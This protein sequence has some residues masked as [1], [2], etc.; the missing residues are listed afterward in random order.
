MVVTQKERSGMLW[1]SLGTPRRKSMGPG[2]QS[3]SSREHLPA[4]DPSSHSRSPAS[5]RWTGR[6]SAGRRGVSSPGSR[7]GLERSSLGV[8]IDSHQPKMGDCR[9]FTS[10]TP[11]PRQWGVNI[12]SHFLGDRF[13][14][15]VNSGFFESPAGV[16]HPG[17]LIIHSKPIQF[18]PI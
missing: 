13:F 4:W 7:S 6:R 1:T 12:S 17:I 14:Q 18:I 3:I 15:I 5:C 11:G 9:H 8:A 2:L 10:S 16:G